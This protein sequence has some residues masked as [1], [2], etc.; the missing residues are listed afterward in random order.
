MRDTTQPVYIYPHTAD[1]P[2][3][4]P[5]HVLQSTYSMHTGNVLTPEQVEAII[6]IGIQMETVLGWQHPRGLHSI[7]D[8]M[9]TY[10]MRKRTQEGI[11]RIVSSFARVVQRFRET[12]ADYAG[13]ETNYAGYI[14]PPCYQ[15]SPPAA[16][17]K[18]WHGLER[19]VAQH[20]KQ[21]A[22]SAAYGGNR[23]GNYRYG[24]AP[25]A[26]RSARYWRHTRAR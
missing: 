25:H 3:T 10:Y 12:I 15:P 7:L 26:Q 4:Q 23:R 24:N 22:Y 13:V 2:C 19:V 1:C 5:M 11:D 17:H 9:R 14:Y 20:R 18:W 21:A 6:T 8:T 16:P